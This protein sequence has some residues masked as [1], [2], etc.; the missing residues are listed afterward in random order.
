M[1]LDYASP[2]LQIEEQLLKQRE[3][4]A[5]ILASR[6]GTP[7]HASPNSTIHP[8]QVAGQMFTAYKAG[9]VRKENEAKARELGETYNKRLSEGVEDYMRRKTGTGVQADPQEFQQAA[10][11]GTP[12]PAPATGDPK[13]AI[14]MALLSRNPLLR[15]IG[16]I[17]YQ[18]QLKKDDPYT[19]NEGDMRVPGGGMPNISNPKVP[20]HSLPTGWEKHVPPNAT[21]EGPGTVRMKGADGLDDLYTLEFERGEYKGLK[22]L[23]NSPKAAQVRVTNEAPVTVTSIIDP[24]DPRRMLQV[25]ARILAHEGM[26][27]FIER[28]K[29]GDARGVIGEGGRLG[30]REKLNAKREFN[31]QGLGATLTEAEN[32]LTGTAT[33]PK[34]GKKLAKPTGSG[35]GAGVDIVAG[36]FGKAPGG[37]A[38]AQRMKA[39]GGALTSKMPRMEGPQSD[40]DVALYKQMAADIGDPTKPREVRLAA[41]QTVRELWQKYE[42]LPENQHAFADRRA[43]PAGGGNVIKFDAQGNI[44]Q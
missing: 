1:A 13:G 10:D 39:I 17:D 41:L 26:N 44:V 6:A 31:M 5:N 19:L 23:D 40:K 15:N 16:S 33:D 32:L 35:V 42:H 9:Q 4:L 21:V 14:Q 38:E 20:L 22:K 37:A 2:D 36:V 7:L 3:N 18:H 43:A 28:Y 8:L 34:T 11:Y 27:K 12:T 24:L 29:A 25:D 30:D